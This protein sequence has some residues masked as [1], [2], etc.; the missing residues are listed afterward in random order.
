MADLLYPCD[1]PCRRAYRLLVRTKDGRQLCPPDWSL[2]GSPEP[3]SAEAK[4]LSV[5]WRARG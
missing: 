4:G 1:G 2:T 5:A 3:L